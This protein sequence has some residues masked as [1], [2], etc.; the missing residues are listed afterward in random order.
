VLASKPSPSKH[1]RRASLKDLCP[2]D[3]QRVK[4]LIE[5][6]ARAGAEK[7]KS[8]VKFSR[9]KKKFQKTLHLL[10]HEQ[11][12]ILKEKESIF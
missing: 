3:K 5:D 1:K 11:K 6:L 12:K 2:E 10:H 9:E 4:Q 8:D 7:E